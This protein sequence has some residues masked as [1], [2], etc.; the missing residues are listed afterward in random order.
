M[1]WEWLK[2]DTSYFGTHRPHKKYLPTDDRLP[3]KMSWSGS[4]D[5]IAQFSIPP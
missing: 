3:H 1:S 5:L 4:R 2:I